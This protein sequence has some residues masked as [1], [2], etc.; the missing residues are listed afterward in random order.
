MQFLEY[1]L[2]ISHDFF[3]RSV[4]LL[5]IL[6]IMFS[7][8]N[9]NASAQ[10]NYNEVINDVKIEM[11]YLEGGIYERGCTAEQVKYCRVDEKPV[12]KVRLKSFYLGKYPVTQKQYEAVMG[13]IPSGF[14]S[15][16]NCPVENLN[17]FEA[18]EFIKKLNELSGQNYRLPTEAEWEYAARGGKQTKG[19]LYSGSNEIEIVGWHYYDKLAVLQPVGQKDPNE[20]GIFDMSGN[21]WEWCSDWYGEYSSNN[22]NN[23]KGPSQGRFKVLRGGSWNVSENHCRVSRRHRYFPNTKTFDFGFRLAKDAE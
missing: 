7:I 9:F 19:F 21:V 1:I 10:G 8:F 3:S 5:S 14:K 13:K 20:A 23:P 16:A 18:N 2:N 11:V 22:I 6:L 4:K 15:C 12:H 17:W